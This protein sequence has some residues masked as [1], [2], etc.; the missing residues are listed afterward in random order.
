MTPELKAKW[1]AALRSRDFKQ[2]KA[3]LKGGLIKEGRGA[4][5]YIGIGHCCLGVLCEV[6]GTVPKLI[7]IGAEEIEVFETYEDDEGSSQTGSFQECLDN[8]VRRFLGLPESVASEAMSRNDG[9]NGF[10]V[11]GPQTFAEIADWLEGVL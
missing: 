1:L 11:S 9:S 8:D 2:I 5:V 10:K 3:R 7:R 6:V 4:P